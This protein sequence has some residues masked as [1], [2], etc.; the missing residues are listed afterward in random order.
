MWRIF[1]RS[2]HRE[3]SSLIFSF[4]HVYVYACMR[5]RRGEESDAE[6]GVDKAISQGNLEPQTKCQTN[7]LRVVGGDGYH[8]ALHTEVAQDYIVPHR[9]G[10]IDTR[11]AKHLTSAYGDRAKVVTRIAED[12]RLGQRLA[13]GRRPIGDS[14]LTRTRPLAI[15]PPEAS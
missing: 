9:P 8:P 7:Y 11:V 4:M 1:L 14:L 6:Q 12:K 13:R 3:I 5:G 2:Q 10:A 15:T